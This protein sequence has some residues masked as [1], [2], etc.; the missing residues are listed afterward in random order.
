M[1]MNKKFMDFF[2]GGGR[3]NQD[4]VWVFHN[5]EGEILLVILKQQRFEGKSYGMGLFWMFLHPMGPN[6]I[7]YTPFMDELPDLDLGME[8]AQPQASGKWKLRDES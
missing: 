1:N 8:Q 7:L 5:Q 6:P 3:R 2:L 4:W